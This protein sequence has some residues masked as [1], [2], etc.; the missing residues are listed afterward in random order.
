MRGTLFRTFD[1]LL[2]KNVVLSYTRL[3]YVLRQATW[4]DA[5]LD[6]DMT[7]RV[8]LVTGATSGL[9]LVTA[10]GLARLGATVYM[11]IRNE[12][13]GRWVREGIIR[14]TGNE[15]VHLEI[16]DLSSLASV[17]ALAKRFLDRESRLDVLSR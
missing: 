8:C 6:V 14:R 4:R 5:D 2:D 7:G 3:G 15:N 1:T 16:A 9:G 13:K 11:I 12:G 17:R 10:E